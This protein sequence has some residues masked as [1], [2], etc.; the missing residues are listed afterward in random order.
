MDSDNRTSVL[1]VNALRYRDRSFEPR[2]GH[3]PARVAPGRIGGRSGRY[4]P[5][6]RTQSKS[7]LTLSSCLAQVIRS[8]M[9][10]LEREGCA[11]LLPRV[12]M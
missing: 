9:P 5:N 3:L 2:S 1:L 4:D 8:S 7:D 10:G 12:G 11:R 6:C